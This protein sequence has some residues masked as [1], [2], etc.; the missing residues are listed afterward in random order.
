MVTGWGKLSA[1]RELGRS[2]GDV[3][4]FRPRFVFSWRRY[5]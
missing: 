5:S 2:A 3:E 4:G 1:M